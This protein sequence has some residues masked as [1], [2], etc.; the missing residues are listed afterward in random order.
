MMA[1]HTII[2]KIRIIGMSEGAPDVE[3][4]PQAD[5]LARMVITQD[6]DEEIWLDAYGARA[7]GIYLAEWG[8]KAMSASGQDQNGL[9][10]QPAS[11]VGETDL[12]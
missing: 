6:G 10:A 9:G 11:A 1:E 8:A 4:S 3:A 7:L 12:P 5:Q 2:E